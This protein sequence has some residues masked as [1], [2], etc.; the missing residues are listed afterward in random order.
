MNTITILIWITIVIIAIIAIILVKLHFKGSELET[1]EGTI[2]PSSKDLSDALSIGKQNNSSES[3]SQNHPRSLSP[4]TTQNKSHSIFKKE[5]NTPKE[6]PI[7]IVPESSSNNNLKKYEYKSQN[8]VLINYDNTVEKFQEPIKQSQMDIMT[9]NKDKDTTELKD[10]FTI[11]ELIKESKRKDNERE[12]ESQTIKRDEDKELIEIKESIK[13]KKEEPLIEE[14]ID[15]KEEELLEETMDEKEESL[16]EETN[17]EKEETIGSIIK[18]TQSNDIADI[19]SSEEIKDEK[20]PI[21]TQ[22]EPDDTITTTSKESENEVESNTEDK[23]ITDVL[24]NKVKENLEEISEPALKTPSKVEPDT[25]SSEN[26]EYNELDYRK[27]LDKITSK[28]KESKIFQDVKEKLTPEPVEEDPFDEETYI[29][30]VN[31]Y[32][33]YEPIIKETHIDF[34]ENYGYEMDDLR[35]ENTQRMFNMSKTQETV[36]PQPIVNEIKNKPARDNIKININNN[37]L[38]LKKG[39]EIIFNH[40]GETYSSQ[41]YAINGD[42]ISVR[43]RRKNIKIKPSDVKKIY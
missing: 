37:E 11:D 23:N 12:K 9:Q 24:L 16:I 6:D 2:L 20:P 13:N 27:D 32:E 43:Y 21:P 40:K 5:D 10:L 3:S 42:D 36:A 39:D 25:S 38:V 1:E 18:E 41:V 17:D 35:Q 22:K 31:E 33:E 8:Q 28:I 7:Y 29:R 34:E 30:R 4:Q 15:E 19:I 14:I 26:E